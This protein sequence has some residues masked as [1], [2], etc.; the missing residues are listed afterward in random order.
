MSKKI[1][2]AAVVV[3]EYEKDGETKSEW[4]NVGVVLKADDKP[5]FLL[6]DRTFNPAGIP[7]PDGR[8]NVLIS[9]FK[10]KEKD[11]PKDSEEDF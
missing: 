1:Y 4:L 11:K 2:V 6:L 7:N 3:G 8:K 10:P 5:P 9:F